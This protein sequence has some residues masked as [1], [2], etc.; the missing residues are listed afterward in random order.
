MN[1]SLILLLGAV[2]SVIITVATENV[3]FLS[4]SFILIV[5][6]LS[7]WTFLTESEEKKQ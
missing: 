6:S 5:M 2:G 3:I 1:K 7:E 4:T